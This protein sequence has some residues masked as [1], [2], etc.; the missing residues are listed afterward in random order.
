MTLGAAEPHVRCLIVEDSSL[1]L[2]GLIDTL[3]GM[4]PLKVVGCAGDEAAA[5]L[6]LDEMG[7]DVDLVIAD[8]FLKQ[9]TGLGVLN[10]ANK[11]KLSCRRVVLTNYA[12]SEMRARCK[13]LHA[14]RVF[15]K[16]SELDELIE[17]CEGLASGLVSALPPGK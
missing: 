12:T 10:H 16:S 1:I 6:L 3:Q 17:Y 14:D 2:Q 13:A 5:C 8:V 11:L 15:D 7:S 4:L 9:G